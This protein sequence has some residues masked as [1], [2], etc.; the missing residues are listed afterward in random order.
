MNA[1]AHAVEALYSPE[2]NPVIP[3]LAMEGIAALVRAL[4]AIVNNPVDRDARSDALYGAWDLEG[5]L[6][7]LAAEIGFSKDRCCL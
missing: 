4:P 3:L 5:A 7:C 6:R 1:I 2:A